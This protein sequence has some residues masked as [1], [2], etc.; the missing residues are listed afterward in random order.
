MKNVFLSIFFLNIV[1]AAMGQSTM[2]LST[3]TACF[4]EQLYV[5]IAGQNTLFEQG[6]STFVLESETVFEYGYNTQIVS[7]TIAYT[8]FDLS[9]VT[10]GSYTV[11]CYEAVD[12]SVV[13]SNKLYVQAPSLLSDVP[14]ESTPN[15][16]SLNVTITGACTNFQ[17]ASSTSNTVA[18]LQ[19]SQHQ[20]PANFVNVT[21]NTRLVAN[22]TLPANVPLGYY[23][24][25]TSD[26][27]DGFLHIHNGFEIVN[28]LGIP[29][30]K[31]EDVKVFP[32]PA[33]GLLFVE[34]G[35]VVPS[36]ISLMDMNGRVVYEKNHALQKE[37]LAIGNLA[38]GL[39]ILC[40]ADLSGNQVFKKITIQ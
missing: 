12:D 37:E 18:W 7:N 33:S 6:S 13:A 32:N 21:S 34:C 4:G 25:Y 36:F 24:V 26:N 31:A 28:S 2:T 38:E 35:G 23:D 8:N 19:Q 20:I 1:G 16:A 10:P 11:V 30:I 14:N 5:A 29:A 9:Q 15:V 40:I 3:D 22:F 27:F 17:S 39:Y